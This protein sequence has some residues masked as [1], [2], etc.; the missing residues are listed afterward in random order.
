[1]HFPKARDHAW[2]NWA[3]LFQNVSGESFILK[4]GCTEKAYK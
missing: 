4:K 1:M 2:D 3:D